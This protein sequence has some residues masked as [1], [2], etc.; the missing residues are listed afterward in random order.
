MLQKQSLPLSFQSGMDTKTDSKQLDLGTMYEIVN[1]V[2]TSPKKIEKRNGYNALSTYDSNDDALP[3]LQSLAVFNNGLV[4]FSDTALY[5]YSENTQKWVN[6]GAIANLS[7]ASTSVLRNSYNTTKVHSAASNDIGVFVWK[8]SRGGCRYS[9]VDLDT[10]TLFQSDAV[11][12]SSAEDP[13]VVVNQNQFYLFYRETGVIYYKKINAGTPTLIGGA[14][15]VKSNLTS[16]DPRYD[17]KTVTDRIYVA[18]NS[19][20]V[21]NKLQ[22]FYINSADAISSASSFNVAASECITITSDNQNRIWVAYY[23]GTSVFALC[24]A[25]TLGATLLGVTTIET[26]GSVINVSLAETSTGTMTLLYTVTASPTANSLIRKNT[27][28]LAGTVGTAAVFL[29]SV[30]QASKIFENNDIFYTL[31]LHQSSASLQNTYFLVDLSG[32]VQARFSP[33]TAGTELGKSTL[34]EVYNIVDD[35]YLLP[36]QVTSI[37]ATSDTTNFV[38]TYGVNRT[39]VNFVPT[40]NYQDSTLGQNLYVAGGTLRNYDGATVTEDGFFVYPEGLAA[41]TNASSGG[42]MSNG[43]FQYVAVYSW[44][45]NRGQL[46]RSATSLPLS[47]TTSAGGTTQTQIVAVPTLRLTQKESVFIELYRTEASGSIF[48]AVTSLTSPNFNDKTANSINI[49]DTLS[50]ATLITKEQLYTTGGV[51]DNDPAPNASIVV[52]WKNRLV[53]AGLEDEQQLSY[54][55]EYSPG[56]PAQFSDFFRITVSNQGGP[57]TA[58]GILD[59]KLIIFKKSL[60]FALAGS[61]PNALGEQNDYGVPEIVSSDAGCAD[62]SSVVITPVGLMF[63]SSKG[64]YLLDRGLSVQ[65]IGAPVEKYNALQITAATLYSSNNQ[66]RFLTSENLALVYD[67]YFQKWSVFDNHGGKDAEILGDKYVYLRN[68]NLVFEQDGSFLDNGQP[69]SLQVDTGWLSFAGV[70]GFQRVYKMLGLGDFFSAHRLKIETAF[71]YQSIYIESKTINSEDFI[72]SSTYGSGSPYGSDTYYGGDSNLTAYQFRVD[73]KTQKA[74]SIRVKIKEL[75]NDTYGRGLSLSNLNFEV[76]VK[77]GTGKLNQSQ[78]F[79]TN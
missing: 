52:N 58:L 66:V 9:V 55:K 79:G 42:F 8:D 40:L 4:S 13:R 34:S 12:S 69:I 76:G 61:G 45:D 7:V 5:S 19:T 48:Y 30:S 20:V 33:G 14:V 60:I 78:T 44:F 75:Q 15:T 6:K 39:V 63:K 41:G 57:I 37:V 16:A 47:V 68:D 36:S 11:L 22:I 62:P 59:D 56:S 29:R 71:N 53:L 23:N 24:L 64:I 54:S 43:T 77:S 35:K 74:Q 51:L 25:Y 31:V 28:T 32:V 65:Y 3:T 21:G 67:T 2:Y 27:V 49:T 10:N 38:S 26:V 17:V 46:H 72:N 70:Q 50:D 1:G 18:Y 73:M